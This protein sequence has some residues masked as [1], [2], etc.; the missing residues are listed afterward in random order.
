MPP[1]WLPHFTVENAASAARP[2][3]CLGGRTIVAA[4]ESHIGRIAMIADPQRA[5]FA[6]F[7]GE[8]ES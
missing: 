6:V 1:S 3:E 4:S 5:A 7:K 8:T 2:A